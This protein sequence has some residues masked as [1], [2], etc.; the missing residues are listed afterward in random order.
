MVWSDDVERTRSFYERL[1]LKFVREQ[2]FG[3]PLHY[4][5]QVGGDVFEVYPA[6]RDGSKAKFIEPPRVRLNQRG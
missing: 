2:H 4:A 6:T 5:A 1:G 3:G